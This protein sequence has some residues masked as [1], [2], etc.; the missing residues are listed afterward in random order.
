MTLGGRIP[1]SGWVDEL[2][3]PHARAR[4]SAGLPWADGDEVL[5]V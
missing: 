5:V 3:A 2:P 4:R 1:H